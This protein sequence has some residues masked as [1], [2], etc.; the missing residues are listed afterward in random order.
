MTPDHHLE[1]VRDIAELKTQISNMA[2][3]VTSVV[4]KLESIDAVQREVIRI[5]QEQTDHRESIKRAFDRIEVSERAGGTLKESTERWIN[6]GVGAWF[7]GAILMCFI[8]ALIL[9]R[10]KS[11]ENT[12]D[13]HTASLVTID[14]R[15]SW[16]EY[17]IKTHVKTTEQK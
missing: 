7:V 16:M 9:D 1:Q 6:R 12:Q 4:K 10:V 13:A 17:E 14:R 11:Y 8:Q 15:I 2:A 3:D 5:Q